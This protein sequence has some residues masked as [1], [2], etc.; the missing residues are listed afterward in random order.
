MSR[1]Y[2]VHHYAGGNIETRDFNHHLFS[3]SLKDGNEYVI[4]LAGAQYGQCQTVMPMR[5]FYSDWVSASKDPE[6]I[7]GLRDERCRLLEK[8]NVCDMDQDLRSMIVQDKIA[9]K[10]ETLVEEWEQ[11]KGITVD[12]LIH[13]EAAIAEL[14]P[15]RLLD[16]VRSELQSYVQ[17]ALADDTFAFER[18]SGYDEPTFKL[19]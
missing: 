5:A 18:L 12:K 19:R 15:D 11:A 13:Q 17:Q 10:L 2:I 6:P 7:G 14:T 3:V 9:I 1:R 4:D 8:S 16:F